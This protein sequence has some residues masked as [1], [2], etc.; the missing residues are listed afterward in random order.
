E[1]Q[2]V[3]AVSR[4]SSLFSAHQSTI[5]PQISITNPTTASTTVIMMSLTKLK[6]VET[7]S[8]NVSDFLYAKTMAATNNVTIAMVNDIGPV[9]APR[10]KP[11]IL[12]PATTLGIQLT[13]VPITSS[14]GPIAAA[15]EA[16]ITIHCFDLSLKL[17]NFLTMS[18]NQSIIDRI[19]PSPNSEKEIATPSSADF[20]LRIEPARL[21]SITS[22]ISP[23]VPSE[24]ANSL[25]KLP[26]SSAP[27]LTNTLHALMASAPNNVSSVADFCCDDIPSSPFSNCP[28]T[29][30]IDF[31]LPSASNTS[32]PNSFIKLDASL[33]GAA[34]LCSPFLNCLPACPP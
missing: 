5:K 13:R 28:I 10:T 4:I 19:G 34:K 16:N 8:L 15:I 3:F 20:K 27:S 26:N 31:M 30:G 7:T 33:V 22:A 17:S 25:L 21:S 12:N 29:S 9:N 18:V 11:I 1:V 23:A 24:F 14:I 2:I 32:I 6:A